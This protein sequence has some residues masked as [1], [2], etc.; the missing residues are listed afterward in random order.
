MPCVAAKEA[1]E[2]AA[3]VV[4]SISC[5]SPVSVM[6]KPPLSMTIASEA[7]VFIRSSCR[8]SESSCTSSSMS[9]GSVA[10][11]SGFTLALVNELVQQHARDHVQR[12]ED[13]FAFVRASG[14]RW[15]FNLLIIEE[16]IHVFHR[17]DVR[18]IAFV[19]L[20]H[21]R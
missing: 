8:D 4:V 10:I 20:Q 7:S 9:C 15:H 16:E 17:R 21:V 2:R 13:P 6:R 19:V 5:C 12:L 3:N 18:Q 11:L 14:E 1:A